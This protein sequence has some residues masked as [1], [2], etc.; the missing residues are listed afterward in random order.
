MPKRKNIADLI[1]QVFSDNN[2]FS[3][4]IFEFF[5]SILVL[6]LCIIFVIETYPIP[7][8]LF[9]FLITVELAITSF[10]LLEYI[11]RWWALSFSI[12]YLFTG[13]AII[14]FIAILPLFL[15][16]HFQFIRILRLFRVLRLF[17]IFEHHKFAF[18]TLSDYHLR[19][20]RV[21]FTLFSIVFIF[22]GLIYDI[23]HKL[24]P[25][26]FPTFFEAFYYAVSTLSTVG[27]GDI[28]PISTK[29]RL[30]TTMMII[31]GAILIPW[32]ISN[33]VKSIIVN[34]QKKESTCPDCGLTHHDLDAT[35]CKACGHIIY[36]K[37]T[38]HN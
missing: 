23:E 12:R 36:Q 28:V 22:S 35:Y 18:F 5:T 1:R 37:Y 25:K 4:R 6:L 15:S 11:V 2:S 24:N 31:S 21:I 8:S 32:Q 7:E 33:L 17:R 14:D 19:L 34:T 13:L 10:F 3:G 26:A 30:L 9:N 38:S 27:F 29:G 20:I 16:A